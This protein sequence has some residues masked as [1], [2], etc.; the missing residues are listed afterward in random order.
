MAVLRLVAANVTFDDRQR[1][2]AAVD[3][4]MRKTIR[5]PAWARRCFGCNCPA[6]HNTVGCKTCSDRHAHRRSL[7]KPGRRAK[8]NAR[9]RERRRRERAE[10][11]IR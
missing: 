10:N 3:A 8:E 5:E 9:N 11:P 1:I 2:K 7:L 6:D 4:H